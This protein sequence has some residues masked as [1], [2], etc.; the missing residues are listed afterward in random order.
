MKIAVLGFLLMRSINRDLLLGL[1]T[2]IIIVGLI[3]GVISYKIT[4]N[5]EIFVL[6]EQAEVFTEKLARISANPIYLSEPHELS[7]IGR[8]YMKGPYIVAVDIFDA[9]HNRSYVNTYAT[10]EPTFTVEKT[11]TLFE[12]KLGSVKIVFTMEHI[13][14]RQKQMFY[15]TCVLI[16]CYIV[17][18]SIAAIIM[19]RVLLRKPI[20]TLLHN[21][22]TI[23]DGSYKQILPPMKQQYIGQITQAIN[24]MANKISEREN[25]LLSYQEKLRGLTKELL[26]TEERQRRNLATALH[27][28][29]GHALTN[30]AIKIALLKDSVKNDEAGHLLTEMKQLIEQSAQ[31]VRTMIFEISPPVL[32]DLGLMAA[33]D[34]LSEHT[35]KE[36]GLHVTFKHEP[37]LKEL[38]SSLKVLVFHAVRELLFNVRKHAQANKVEVSVFREKGM[39]C[40]SVQDDGIGIRNIHAEDQNKLEGFG[41]FNIRERLSHLN[42]RLTISSRAGK[43]T[44]VVIEIPEV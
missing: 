26:L 11:I 29:I 44:K 1:I 39:L 19:L 2:I 41:L 16:I 40:I 8:E 43:G 4:V 6:R 28:R 38:S 27:D 32:Y 24:V 23:A 22:R 17:V 3:M 20:M 13:V 12:R 15:Y 10:Q 34:W 30:V 25:H 37:E 42:G 5:R 7:T 35:T 14:E 36:R 21:I 33:I 31:D 9:K 18:V